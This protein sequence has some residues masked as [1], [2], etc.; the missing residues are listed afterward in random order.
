M[1][2]K[3]LILGCTLGLLLIF[4]ISCQPSP[5]VKP[6]PEPEPPE[7]TPPP[8][9]KGLTLKSYHRSMSQQMEESYQKADEIMVGIFEASHRDPERGLI[10]Y[11]KDV[12]PFNKETLSWE[13]PISA[14]VQVRPGECKPEI[15]KRRGFKNLIDLDK[16]GICWDF[17]EGKRDIYMVG[18]KKNLIFVNQVI[19]ETQIKSYRTLIDTYPV[20]EKCQA[21]AVFDWMIRNNLLK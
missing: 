8:A 3:I 20:T 15:I 10:Y 18:G 7:P 14:V 19:D 11:F 1:W 9:P 12:I 21:K 5:E 6:E 17:Y 13:S 4:L 16:V 2:K